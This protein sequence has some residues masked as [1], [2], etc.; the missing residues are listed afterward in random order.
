MA[1]Q[2][3]WRGFKLLLADIKLLHKTVMQAALDHNG[4]FGRFGKLHHIIGFI[5][6]GSTDCKCATIGQ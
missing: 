2:G 3:Q 6:F 1:R 4:N 5:G